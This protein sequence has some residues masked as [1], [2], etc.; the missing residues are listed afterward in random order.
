MK[1]IAKLLTILMLLGIYACGGGGADPSE[2]FDPG[3]GSGITPGGD[4]GN[5]QDPV[6]TTVGA[7]VLA[8]YFNNQLVAFGSD[9]TNNNAR[10]YGL[11]RATVRNTSNEP[12]ANQTINFSALSGSFSPQPSAVTNE[13]GVAQIYL[14]APANLGSDKVF[15]ST[16][17][18]IS[19][20]LQ[21]TY[22][23]GPPASIILGASPNAVGPGGSSTIT[24]YLRDANGFPV[25]NQ[26]CTFTI[27]TNATGDSANV[28]PIIVSSDGTGRATT[29]YTAGPGTGTDVLTAAAGA[30]NT[31]QG[32]VVTQEATFLQ[33]LALQTASSTLVANGVDYT[34]LTATVRDNTGKA[35]EGIAVLFS[36]TLGTVKEI[37]EAG[38]GSSNVTVS[39]D[40]NGFARAILVSSIATGEAE[41]KASAGGLSN[42]RVVSYVPGPPASVILQSFPSTVAPTGTATLTAIVKDENNHP[43]SGR[44]VAFEFLSKGSGNPALSAIEV[45][46]NIIGEAT[47]TYT[48]GIQ[49]GTDSI[50]ARALTN[51]TSSAPH[52]ITV[53]ADTSTGVVNSITLTAG[54]QSIVA[55]GQSE[56]A[57]RA[58]VRDTLGKP[59]AGFQVD[60]T[61]TAG[62]LVGGDVSPSSATTDTNGV[63][64]VRLKS[65]SS[66]G[67]ALIIGTV[68]GFS[69]STSV[70]FVP[71]PVAAIFLNASP[72]ELGAGGQATVTATVTDAKGNPVSGETVQF[73]FADFSA[74]ESGAVLSNAI[75][76]TDNNGRFSILY[77]A[78]QIAGTTDTISARSTNDTNN[79]TEITIGTAVSNIASLNLVAASPSIS[80]DGNSTSLIQA[81]VT[82]TD[83]QP[84]SGVSVTFA[85]TQ[86]GLSSTSAPTEANG[87]ASVMLTSAAKPGVATV[88]ASTGGFTKEV[89]VAFVPGGADADKSSITAS[90]STLPPD[91]AS[92]TE[93]T[94]VLVD[95]VGNLVSNGTPVTLYSSKGTIISANPTTTSSGRALFTLQAPSVQGTTTL[96]VAEV[97]GLEGTITFGTSSTGD[98]AN[99]LLS[100]A[101]PTIFVAG[102]G[103]KENTTVTIQIQEANGTPIDE[104]LFSGNTARVSFITSPGGGEYISGMNAAGQ[105]VAALPGSSIDVVTTGGSASLNLQA[106][107][108]PG[109]VEIRVEALGTD[110]APLS[111]PVV[112]SLP[113]VNI[114][115]GPPHTIKLSHPMTNSVIDLNNVTSLPANWERV[116][117]FY[118]RV[119]GASV[120][121]RYGNDVPDG[122]IINLGLVDSV[123]TM[124]TTGWTASGSGTLTDP[125][126]DFLGD[127][128]IRNNAPRY[129]QNNDRILVLN[130]QSEDKS[131]FVTENTTRTATTIKTNASY[132]TAANSLHYVVGASLQGA[133]ISGEDEEGN[134]TKGTAKVKSG[135][136]K[137]WVTYPANAGT[138]LNGCY[139]YFGAGPDSYFKGDVR[140]YPPESAQV[141]VVASTSN[142]GAATVDRGTFCFASIAGDGGGESGTLT[143]TPST[144]QA[145]APGSQYVTLILQD[146]GDGVLLPFWPIVSMVYYDQLGTY[147]ACSDS[148]HN[149]RATCEAAAFQ[150]QTGLKSDFNVSVDLSYNGGTIGNE[151]LTD[152]NGRFVAEVLVTGDNMVSGD[153]ATITFLANGTTVS[154]QVTVEV[155]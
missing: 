87:V 76:T 72:S 121:D 135:T 140:F 75:G 155:P 153:K 124:G 130:A 116:P 47:V 95:A 94:V 2:V 52:Q 65:A 18:V 98:P 22:I 25:P 82:G 90:P 102:V 111:P 125:S 77:T 49:S 126:G 9:P 88:T 154:T 68:Q 4:D 112:A 144:L 54:A 53:S 149:T 86:G 12:L 118:R 145:R 6:N 131:R 119:G 45:T 133:Y 37:G 103:Q 141:Y 81:T 115:S 63:A 85:T 104:N 74:N 113:Q 80:A 61:A 36:T 89:Q 26:N 122:T 44:K 27:S 108:L 35:L 84:K 136:A 42:T 50:R 92:T 62:N 19:N 56:T 66:L 64:E 48:A 73:Y 41:I 105:I 7:I 28:N 71:G 43:V 129:I 110:G 31:T 146:G 57:I 138:I 1:T 117:G 16:G 143:P 55:D 83:G 8:G 11:I 39:S 151:G 51:N 20:E 139:R 69:H 147:D 17:G 96:T 23:N 46:T 142:N 134:L 30:A 148:S 91:G 29:Q 97:G 3:P 5:I 14:V 32:I 78:G 21:V 24:A 128:I 132:S 40:T 100:V 114:A 107:I 10:S 79:S 93:I 127:F 38:S 99:I 120:T 15:A 137:F 106:G 70:K 33:T 101:N 59:A 109:P 60:F 123:I 58:T 13:F 152:I 67:T 150:W 34:T